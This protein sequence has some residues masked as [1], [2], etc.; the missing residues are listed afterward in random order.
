GCSTPCDVQADCTATAS[1]CTSIYPASADQDELKVCLQPCQV[2]DDCDPSLH[3]ANT[4]DGQG[5]CGPELLVGLSD[6]NRLGS[7]CTSQAECGDAQY[8][9]VLAEGN[10]GVCT[11]PCEE[12]SD[13]GPF[14]EANAICLQA[15]SYGLCA[16]GCESN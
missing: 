11:A 6:D 16:Q 10:P 8:C 2:D 14:L 4:S 15:G 1:I 5:V 3:C 9:L 12:S 13:C 7:R